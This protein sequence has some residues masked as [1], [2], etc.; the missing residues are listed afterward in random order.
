MEKICVPYRQ[1]HVTVSYVVHS[2][3]FGSQA[4]N[5]FASENIVLS[6]GKSTDTTHWEKLINAAG[7]FS[8]TR[9][10]SG[11]VINRA[12]FFALFF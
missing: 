1:N 9:K 4:G 2:A 10:A 5:Q 3:L 11:L 12:Q 7:D 6:P 8:S